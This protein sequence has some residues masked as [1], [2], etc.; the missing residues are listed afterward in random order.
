MADS[1]YN[2]DAAWSAMQKGASD[3]TSDALAGGDLTL[4]VTPSGDPGASGVT[5]DVTIYMR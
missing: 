2:W 5:T 1:G 3:W 4:T